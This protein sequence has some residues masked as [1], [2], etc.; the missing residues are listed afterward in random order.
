MCKNKGF[1]LIELMAVL[2]CFL[3]L[4]LVTVA[5]WQH[6]AMKMKQDITV[7]QVKNGLVYAR[8]QAIEHKTHMVYCGSSDLQ[9][10]DGN[11]QYAEIIKDKQSGMVL[12]SHVLD[13][14][15]MLINFRS[16]F[17][18]TRAIEFTPQGMTYGQQGHFTICVPASFLVSHPCRQ[19]MVHFSGEV[20]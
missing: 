7:Y 2:S 16:N 4:S 15:S 20:L 1:S 8:N 5:T 14:Q 10:C 19:L 18:N 6:Y 13:T 11:W 17:G 3:V 9:H 12:K